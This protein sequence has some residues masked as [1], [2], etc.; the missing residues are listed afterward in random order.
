MLLQQPFS[1]AKKPP[2]I[3]ATHSHSLCRRINRYQQFKNFEKR[4]M[5]ATDLFGRGIDIERVNI[6][7]NYD[8]PESSDSYLHRY[9][10]H[11]HVVY[12]YLYRWLYMY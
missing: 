3:P 4:I 2:L 9:G 10:R 7:V 12:I 8:M 6:V 1:R 5:V 11:V